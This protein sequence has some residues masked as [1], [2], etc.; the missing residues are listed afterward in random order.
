[1]DT[2]NTSHPT[3]HTN[4]DTHQEPIQAWLAGYDR[5]STRNSYRRGL[6]LFCHYLDQT[7][8]DLFEAT[9]EHIGA[10][11]DTLDTQGASRSTQGHRVSAITRF[12]DHAAHNPSTPLTSPPIP[13]RPHQGGKNTS[14][15]TLT[16]SQV[17]DVL[18]A[19]WENGP[20]IYALVRL[21]LATGVKV[22]DALNITEFDLFPDAIRVR[23]VRSP[24]VVVPVDQKTRTALGLLV[25]DHTPGMVIF[26]TRTGNLWARASVHVILKQVGLSAGIDGH[27]TSGTLRATHHKYPDLFD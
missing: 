10:F 5:R 9:G 27:L 26:T 23:P 14:L 13:P 2:T 18:E 4:W 22:S 20:R 1:M 19:A 3:P 24:E 21:L 11:R 17:N 25:K 15:D 16:P 6:Y 8:V 7:G 12:Y